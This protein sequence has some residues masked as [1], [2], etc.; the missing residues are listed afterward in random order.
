LIR[1]LVSRALE[2]ALTEY[3]IK[4]LVA[5]FKCYK[6]GISLPSTF[7]KDV[8]YNHT[9]TLSTVKSEEIYHIHLDS[10]EYPGNIPQEMRTSDNHL[11]YCANFY[12]TDIYLL[13]AILQPN[14]HQ[15]ARDN[16]IM[17]NL[18]QMANNFRNKNF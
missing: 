11:V 9:H 6:E 15:Q 12:S 8:P 5:E 7:G 2:E 13:M 10:D 17:L 1:V 16:S 18:A 3:E 14:A 4:S